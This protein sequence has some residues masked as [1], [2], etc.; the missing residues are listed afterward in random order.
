MVY[1]TYIELQIKPSGRCSDTAVI[2]LCGRG[3]RS[4]A[5]GLILLYE[6]KILHICGGDAVSDC[7]REER[8]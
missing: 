7:L 1:V 8:R 5:N 4:R 6:K 3:L 2:F